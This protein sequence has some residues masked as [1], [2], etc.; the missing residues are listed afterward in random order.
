MLIAATHEANSPSVL[1][2]P[3]GGKPQEKGGKKN[4]SAHLESIAILSG[5]CSSINNTC[6]KE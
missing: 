6:K 4:E 1:E 2:L 5:T 3:P